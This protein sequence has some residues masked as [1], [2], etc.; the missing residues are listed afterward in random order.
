MNSMLPAGQLRTHHVGPYATETLAIEVT[1]LAKAGGPLTK[2]ISLNEADGLVSD[3]SACV[4]SSG[5]ARRVLLGGL[6]DFA[7][8]ITD[9]G[10]CDAVALGALRA[11]LPDRVD[12]T[13]KRRLDQGAA[14]A[15]A[16][17]AEFISYRPGQP[18]LV[19]IDVDTKGMPSEVAG[20]VAA[21]GGFWP[22]I[23]GVLPE[24]AACGRVVRNST[25][26]GLYRTDTGERLAGSSGQHIFVPLADGSDA[27]RFLRTLHR[28]CWLGGLGW[29]MVGA[30]GQ[31]LDRS[32]VDRTVCAPERLV[33]EGAP[34][35]TEPLRQDPEQ[36]RPQVVAG[37]ALDSRAAC[38]DL[39]LVE[40]ARLKEL[41]AAEAVRLA[42]AAGEGKRAFVERQGRRIVERTGCSPAAAARVVERQCAG[43]LLPDVEL[44]F[45]VEEFAGA[46]V[47][48]VLADPDRFTGA[49][50]SDPLEGP[51]YGRGKAKVMRRPDGM[52][53]IHSFAHG[54]TVYELRHDARAVERAVQDA[55]P[56]EAVPTFVRMALQSELAPDEEQTLR[57]RA[58]HIGGVKARPLAAKLKAAREDHA[59]ARAEATRQQHAAQRRDRRLRLPVP[60]PDAER[61]PVLRDLDEV[62]TGTDVPE[63]PMRDLD[64]HPVEVRS[65]P[66]MLLHELS[67]AGANQDEAPK[68]RLPPPALPL[69]TR[70]DR[71]S[72]AHAIEG[73]VEY[74]AESD[75]D[76]RPVALPP[77]FVDH[78]MHYRDSALPRVGA[79]VT[80]PLVLP[81]G[82]L[83]APV[84]LDES[85]RL[86]FRIEPELLTLLPD[87]KKCTRPEAATALDFLVNTWL[88]DVATDFSGK[89]VLIAFALSIIERVL[90][91]ERPAF[92][93]TAGKR[94]GGKTTALTM[95]IL[96]VTGKKPPAA[97]WS[98]SEEERRKAMLAYLSEGL[99]A[100]VWDNVPSGATISCPTIEKVL[101]AET[102]SD[103]V[104]GQT[105]NR[106]VPATTIQGFTGNNIGP[107]GDL[108]SRSLRCRLEVERPDPE[109]RPFKHGDPIAWTVDH[110]GEVLQALYTILLANPQLLPAYR[111]PAKT[112]FKAWWHLVGSAI[113]NAADALTARKHPLSTA[114]V[115]SGTGSR[116]QAAWSTARALIAAQCQGSSSSRRRA[117][118]SAMRAS[119]SA[120][121]ACGSM[122]F[123]L[124]VTMRLY[125]TAARCPPRSEPQNSHDRRPRAI[126]LRARSAALF[127]R[128][129]R[130]SSRNR[131]N[132]VQRLSR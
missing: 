19:L 13:T 22:A 28:R 124:A 86:V 51:D 113:E 60:S 42:P 24:L 11:D 104:L 45:D 121:Q 128:Q 25:S 32:L 97:A 132:A 44:P 106:T 2:R 46:T 122:S 91:P 55:P 77:V 63:P 31:L 112:R 96:A 83:L 105:T 41:R 39:R 48:D 40:Q 102:Y 56:E 85:R 93:V 33:F 129:T 87:P 52:V 6:A 34:I 99:A 62:L 67:A 50:M 15:I 1:A 47:A 69:L 81:D 14:G 110:R 57:E 79:V 54:R 130:P 114:D 38:L 29:F 8:F 72:L 98:P 27:E 10:A 80:A 26:S 76:I 9:L 3:G 78:F 74:V 58:G 127:E 18:A 131:V 59:Q 53:W 118:W 115:P 120:S 101:T 65:R 7:T 107:R 68:T 49:T 88:C 73:Y 125:I 43:V 119:T 108:A 116:D 12:I 17:T 20:K 30:G 35:L 23:A 94:G 82:A 4:M 61:L 71:F 123:I 100:L 109:N 64:G 21:A 5:M 90:L 66:P 117:G 89:C 84:G 70:H 75:E 103:R 126:P 36:R 111:K 16:R 95:V 37:G 92:F